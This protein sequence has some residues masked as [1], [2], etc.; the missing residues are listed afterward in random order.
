[1][2]SA[3]DEMVRV[4][5]ERAVQRDD[6]AALPELVEAHVADPEF[7][8]T[9]IDVGIVGD[10]LA[11]EVPRQPGDERS[12]PSGADDAD[13]LA[14]EVEADKP[15]E[16][17]VAVAHPVVGLVDATVQRQDQRDRV[18]GDRVRRVG[19]DPHDVE[20]E[21][22]GCHEVDVVEPGAAERD[23]AN[24]DRGECRE[25]GVIEHVVHE[26]AHR[27]GA[28]GERYR[29]QP[30]PIL[31]LDDLMT[32]QLVGAAKRHRFVRLG[33]V[34]RNSHPASIPSPWALQVIVRSR[35]SGGPAGSPRA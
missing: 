8:E 4:R 21:P 27:L 29:R 25:G 14:G 18:L 2:T 20:A 12:D 5:R 32:R 3:D 26:H 28:V 13:G 35:A 33:R 30:Q 31:E 16:G 7:Q 9:L 11:P 6:V 10:H 24:P 15:V 22:G 17:E 23:V 1:M 34:H 19:G